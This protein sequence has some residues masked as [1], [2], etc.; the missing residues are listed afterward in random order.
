MKCEKRAFDSMDEA[1]KRSGEINKENAH[2]KGAKP[3]RPYRCGDCQKWHLTSMTKHQ[4]KYKS[5]K[6]YRNH[7]NERAFIKRESEH[8]ERYFARK[9]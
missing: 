6:N 5:N 4:F 9:K 1:Q 2:K 3:L 8:W 7:V